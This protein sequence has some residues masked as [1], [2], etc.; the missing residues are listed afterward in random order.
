[1]THNTQNTKEPL[2]KY[3]LGL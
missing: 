3:L 2:Q 1:M